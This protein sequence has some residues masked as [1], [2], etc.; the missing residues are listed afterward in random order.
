MWLEILK[1][2]K[3]TPS[4]PFCASISKFNKEKSILNRYLE[5]KSEK[6]ISASIHI[7]FYAKHFIVTESIHALSS[8]FTLLSLG[9]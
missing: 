2:K 9:K 3:Y 6:F 5:Q 7:F 8:Y 4:F 1:T